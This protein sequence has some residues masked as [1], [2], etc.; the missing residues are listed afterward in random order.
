MEEPSLTGGFHGGVRAA[1][2]SATKPKPSLSQLLE[3]LAGMKRGLMEQWREDEKYQRYAGIPAKVP[4]STAISSEGVPFRVID[5]DLAPFAPIGDAG[6]QRLSVFAR[7][8]LAKSTLDGEENVDGVSVLFE[9]GVDAGAR[10]EAQATAGAPVIRCRSINLENNALTA[11]GAK[12]LA[13]FIV[14]T[15]SQPYL[16]EVNL[17]WNRIGDHGRNSEVSTTLGSSNPLASSAATQGAFA[18]G[19]FEMLCEVLAQCPNLRKVNLSNCGLDTRSAINGLLALIRPRNESGAVSTAAASATGPI[20]PKPSEDAQTGTWANRTGEQ[21]LILDLSSNSLDLRIPLTSTVAALDAYSSSGL[22]ILD[23]L[24]ARARH[25]SKPALPPVMLKLRGNFRSQQFAQL[26]ESPIDQIEAQLAELAANSS[27]ASPMAPSYDPS[28]KRDAVTT[29]STEPGT[30]QISAQ[31]SQIQTQ[32]PNVENSGPVGS[33]TLTT[34]LAL[35]VGHAF[36]AAAAAGD[37][38]PEYCLKLGSLD[39]LKALVKAQHELALVKRELQERTGRLEELEQECVRLRAELAHATAAVTA[40]QSGQEDLIRKAVLEATAEVRAKA[41]SE[42]AAH[43]GELHALREALT[44]AQKRAETAAVEVQLLREQLSQAEACIA[45]EKAAAS[46]AR[47]DAEEAQQRVQ[48]VRE[49]AKLEAENE[50]LQRARKAEDLLAEE[51]LVTSALRVRLETEQKLAQEAKALAHTRAEEIASL[52]VQ[53]SEVDVLKKGLEEVKAEKTESQRECAILQQKLK[54]QEQELERWRDREAKWAEERRRLQ[55]EIDAASEE[56]KLHRRLVI[57]KESEI[58]SLQATLAHTSQMLEFAQNRLETMEK[59]QE[60]RQ[61]R[62]FAGARQQTSQDSVSHA[63]PMATYESGSDTD[64]G[65][66]DVVIAS[67]RPAQATPVKAAVSQ[68]RSQRRVET[69][70]PQPPAHVHKAPTAQ[71]SVGKPTSRTTAPDRTM[72]AAS[73]HGGSSPREEDS[74]SEADIHIREDNEG[75]ALDEDEDLED[76]S[77]SGRRSNYTTYRT[78]SESEAE[79]EEEL[80]RRQEAASQEQVGAKRASGGA[81]VATAPM[82]KPSAPMSRHGDI[83]MNSVDSEDP[84]YYLDESLS[85]FGLSSQARRTGN[86]QQ[87]RQPVQHQDSDEIEIEVEGDEGYD[88]YYEPEENAGV[89]RSTHESEYDIEFE[90]SIVSAKPTTSSTGVSRSSAFAAGQPTRPVQ[91]TLAKA[92]PAVPTTTSVAKSA[93]PNPYAQSTPMHHHALASASLR[94]AP[95]AYEVNDEDEDEYEIEIE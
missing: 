53:L 14:D 74:E 21:G 2:Q 13:R 55:A 9:A 41:E 35:G 62:A 7:Q 70:P 40:A 45:A 52:N 82:A 78:L 47:K 86:N 75:E 6:M 87:H 48:V 84:R 61:A 36:L 43:A 12:D 63:N 19:G 28:R 11:A 67:R 37:R 85:S 42:A 72:T 69:Q 38:S 18:K 16:R 5:L 17:A 51:K 92:Q 76:E 8:Y 25:A 3:Q 34:G 91:P 26:V 80:R 77:K 81:A 56:R 89:S 4:G 73:V 65:D 15:K 66:V 93:F 58:S 23:A 94:P 64:E 54:L 31:P 44:S 30:N 46:A 27:K 22:R 60:A 79:Y 95:T 29:S 71:E 32:D 39:R 59:A 24:V 20:N 33:T 83:S 68:D 88:Y 90:D 1:T 10:S 49:S 57:A 50:L